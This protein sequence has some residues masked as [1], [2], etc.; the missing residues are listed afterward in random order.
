MNEMLGCERMSRR[1]WTVRATV[2]RE[3]DDGWRT[4]DQVPTFF[5]HMDVQG[6]LDTEHAERV[7]HRVVDPFGL[8]EVH[9]SVAPPEDLEDAQRKARAQELTPLY[10]PG[11]II[12][13]RDVPYPPP[14]N[15]MRCPK[16]GEL[17][18]VM[19]PLGTEAVGPC[20]NPACNVVFGGRDNR[21][22]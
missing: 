8:Y 17:F 3:T 12:S 9:V 19:G 10:P 5:L 13:D 22:Q 7:A 16:C 4:T 6:I 21:G 18:T 11:T 2:A 1:M 20:P 15:T 14:G